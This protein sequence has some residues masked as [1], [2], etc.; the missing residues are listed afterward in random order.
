MGTSAT[1]VYLPHMFR[2][3]PPCYSY[4][5]TATTLES[6]YYQQYT[7]SNIKLFIL[8]N[9]AVLALAVALPQ[10]PSGINTTNFDAILAIV[11][12]APDYSSNPTEASADENRCDKCR[13]EVTLCIFSSRVCANASCP[14]ASKRNRI[15]LGAAANGVLRTGRFARRVKA[16]RAE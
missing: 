13:S 6:V 4:I 10:S 3:A 7:N 9:S 5:N 14:P 8:L 12:E 11:G 16:S 2:S 15:S 1:V